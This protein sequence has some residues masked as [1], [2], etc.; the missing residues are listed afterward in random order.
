MA[1]GERKLTKFNTRPRKPLKAKTGLKKPTGTLGRKSPKKRSKGQKQPSVR[2]LKDKLWNECKRI[3]RERHG[4]TCY[5][6][7]ATGLEGSNW[8][9][10]HSKPKAALPLQF[11]FDIRGLRPQ[12]MKCNVN[13]GGVSDVFIAKLEQ[14]KEGVQF[15]RDA[16]YFDTDWNAW[17][18]RQ[19]IPLLGGKDA[20]IF[21]Q[22]LLEEYKEL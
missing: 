2:Q 12:C 10:G 3:T 8:H 1:F 5:T 21:V 17:R 14:E 19:D 11:K 22:N 7:G 15:L 18:I 9:T 13:L 6:C 20:T 4:N 16:C